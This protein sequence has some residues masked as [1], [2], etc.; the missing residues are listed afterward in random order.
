MKIIILIL[1][2]FLNYK[3]SSQ[4]Q[5]LSYY[6]KPFY[7][8]IGIGTDFGGLGM[9]LEYMFLDY[10]GLFTGVGY[11]LYKLGFNGGFML[12]AT[13]SKKVTLYAS[14][15]YGYTGVVVIEKASQ[16]DRVDYGF[17]LGSGIEIKTKAQNI[18]QIGVVKPFWSKGFE[19]YYQDLL[20]NPSI[21]FKGKL[22]PITFSIGYK[23]V[24]PND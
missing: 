2:L 15:M 6:Q 18:W 17:S 7:I 24:I 8:G 21:Q 14:G 13:P 1:C 11:N 22:R 3:L 9:K 10:A 5:Q 23:L 12:K 16:F 19:K 4:E 20:D